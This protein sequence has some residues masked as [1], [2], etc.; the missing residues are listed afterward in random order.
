MA[1]YTNRLGRLIKTPKIHLTD[2]ALTC[3]LLNVKAKNLQPDWNL[4][5]QLLEAYIYQELQKYDGWQD[6]NPKSIIS[7][8][9]I[10]LKSTLLYKM[11][12]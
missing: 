8:I 7:E 5:Q 2:T 6:S 1:W 4:L 11:V 12:R 3:S 10:K 9:K